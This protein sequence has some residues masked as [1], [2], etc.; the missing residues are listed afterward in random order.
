MRFLDLRLRSHRRNGT[1]SIG[2][3]SESSSTDR[4]RGRR[5]TRLETPSRLRRNRRIRN[6]ISSITSTPLIPHLP[7]PSLP[8]QCT[9]SINLDLLFPL[10]LDASMQDPPPRPPAP[11]NLDPLHLSTLNINVRSILLDLLL[12]PPKPSY[13]PKKNSNLPPSSNSDPN[14]PPAP[15]RLPGAS[16]AAATKKDPIPSRRSSSLPRTQRRER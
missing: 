3:V 16:S 7:T 5:S 1:S 12:L 15:L 6:I 2:S 8:D 14:R 9:R 13:P 11:S 4:R 10:S